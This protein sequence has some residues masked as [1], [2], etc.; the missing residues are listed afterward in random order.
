MLARRKSEIRR[1][2]HYRRLES[3]LSQAQTRQVLAVLQRTEILDALEKR[4][5]S[6]IS[7]LRLRNPRVSAFYSHEE[8]SIT[9]NSGRKLGVHFGGEF[10]PG[11]SRN[12]SWATTDK[13]ESMRRAMLHELAHHFEGFSGATPLMEAGFASPDKRPITRYAGTRWREYFAESFVAHLVDPGGCLTVLGGRGASSIPV[14][15]GVVR[16]AGFATRSTPQRS[17]RQSE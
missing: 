13:G 8:Q 9:L 14:L 2:I 12:M 16:F 5:L 1:G 6:S 15:R 11:S 10:Q 3:D 7:I 4:P 17:D